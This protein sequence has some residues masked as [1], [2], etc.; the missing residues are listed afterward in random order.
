MNFGDALALLER[1]RQL[2]RRCWHDGEYLVIRPDLG[3][4]APYLSLWNPGGTVSVPWT[5]THADLLGDD[6]E[7]L[8][9]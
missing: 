7:L 6:W 9:G 3:T 5:A 4:T 8:H 2:R 1:A